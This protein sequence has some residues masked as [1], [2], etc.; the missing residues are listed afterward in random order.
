MVT[1]V[2]LLR[3]ERT[4]AEGQLSVITS[5]SCS[6]YYITRILDLGRKD[7]ATRLMRCSPTSTKWADT[8]HVLCARL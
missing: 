1:A 7:F 6:S 2:A 5:S 4:C 3:H 8:A